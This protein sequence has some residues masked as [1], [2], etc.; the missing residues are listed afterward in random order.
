MQRSSTARTDFIDTAQPKRAD[1]GIIEVPDP[2][3]GAAST[4]G[5]SFPDFAARND[6]ATLSAARLAGR[7]NAASVSQDEVDALLRERQRL[8]DKT[9]DGTITRQQQNRLSYIEWTLDRVEDARH[10][11]FLDT[12]EAHITRYETL[13]TDLEQLRSKLDSCRAK[14]K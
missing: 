6:P 8:I 13:L 12:M 4:S 10:G 1:R 3:R 9:L 7:M 14:K 5:V 11:E 2:V